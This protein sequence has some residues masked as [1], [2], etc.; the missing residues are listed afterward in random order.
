MG[1]Y[2]ITL[3]FW[4]YYVGASITSVLSLSCETFSTSYM[5]IHLKSP[6]FFFVF[7]FFRS[8]SCRALSI[9]SRFLFE[10]FDPE[11]HIVF[12]VL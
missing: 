6:H 2:A 7:I 1:P 10:I 12:G 11:N 3:T 5:E 8:V 4:S 9:L